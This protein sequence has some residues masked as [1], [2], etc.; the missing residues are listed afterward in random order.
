MDK[1]DEKA[2]GRFP[3]IKPSGSP[4]DGGSASVK[5]RRLGEQPGLPTPYSPCLGTLGPPDGCFRGS[6]DGKG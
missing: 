2:R 1:R 5:V 4:S 3:K 6:L